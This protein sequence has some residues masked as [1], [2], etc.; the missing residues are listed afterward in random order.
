[1]L[2]RAR[3]LWVHLFL[4]AATKGLRRLRA[5]IVPLNV[6]H[7]H[8]NFRHCQVK[9]CARGVITC[10]FQ[11]RPSLSCTMRILPSMYEIDSASTQENLCS[12][13]KNEMQN[14]FAHCFI[15]KNMTMRA[16]AGRRRPAICFACYLIFHFH[17]EAINQ[18]AQPS[19]S[20]NRNDI[21]CI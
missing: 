20:S 12:C 11:S 1:M 21:Q 19:R 14:Y 16:F 13:W 4:S 17:I 15:S 7:P 8:A 6:P 2:S 10:M 3:D 5:C 18:V 9:H